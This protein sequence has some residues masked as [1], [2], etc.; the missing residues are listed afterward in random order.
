MTLMSLKKLRDYAVYIPLD[1][2]LQDYLDEVADVI[3]GEVDA[4][5]IE[6]KKALYDTLIPLP[7]S[8]WCMENQSDVEGY[9]E[10]FYLPKPLFEDGEPVQ[11]GDKAVGAYITAEVVTF[12]VN[13]KGDYFI[14]GVQYQPGERVKRPPSPDTQERIDED[15][16]LSSVRYCE[17]YGIDFDSVDESFGYKYHDL[18]ER[19]R[20]LMGGEEV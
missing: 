15:E 13:D 12:V 2:S 3:Q 16:R 6:R 20:K 7:I 19:Q 5:Y 11:W 18:Y 8:D 10:H 4:E 17:K 9:I 14:N 1:M